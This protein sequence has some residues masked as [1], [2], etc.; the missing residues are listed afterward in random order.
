MIEQLDSTACPTKLSEI[1]SL[2]LKHPS[3]SLA[4]LAAKCRPPITKAAAHHRM[5]VLRRRGPTLGADSGDRS[6]RRG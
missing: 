1:A 4:E 6:S 5:A 3:L 2:R